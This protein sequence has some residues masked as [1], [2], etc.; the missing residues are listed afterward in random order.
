MS[1]QPQP[2]NLRIDKTS[3]P[4]RR[5]WSTQRLSS[6]AISQD[7][8][9]GL[10]LREIGRYP[11]LSA[12]QEYQL[13][14]QW[15][16][17]GAIE[18]AHKLVTSH[19]RFVAKIASGYTGYGLP[20]AEMIAEGNIG[21]MQAVARFNPELGF[22]LAT[23]AM[24]WIKA[25]IQEYILHSWSLV[26][27]GTTA[28][29]KKLFFNLR[30]VKTKLGQVDDDHLSASDLSSVAKQLQVSEKEAANMDERLRRRDLSLNA[31][32]HVDSDSQWQDWLTDRSG[33]QEV[34]LAEKQELQNRQQMLHDVLSQLND[35]E[36]DI[37]S[38]RR[39]AVPQVTLEKLSQ[40]HGISRER[41]RQIEV[42]ALAKLQKLVRGQGHG[43]RLLA[44]T[45]SSSDDTSSRPR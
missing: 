43:T 33:S 27:I 30:R 32:V 28:A 42:R 41:V 2:R 17:Q 7:S 29:Q 36:R 1:P 38:S 14:K 26:K 9:L 10:Y 13:A 19:L 11:L 16:E 45:V 8:N 22:R 12:Q 37:I 15:R 20:L 40:K 18:S 5:P 35:R 3:F 24:W 25:A 6:L 31:P 44:N 21:M 34:M 4:S 23:Y 39:L